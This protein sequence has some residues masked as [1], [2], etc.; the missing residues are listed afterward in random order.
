MPIDTICPS[1]ASTLRVA[2]A[3]AGRTARCPQ[4]GWTYQVP[5]ASAGCS[6]AEQD[7]VY[8]PREPDQRWQLRTPDGNLYGPVTKAILDLWVAEGRVTH[9]SSLCRLASGLWYAAAEIYPQLTP[10]PPVPAEPV[11]AAEPLVA[12]AAVQPG[13]RQAHTVSYVQQPHRG[14]T[15][16][17]LGVLGWLICPV[18]A[19]FTFSM[20]VRDLQAMRAGLMDPEG[21]S[22]TQV[23]VT[24]ALIEIG[25]FLLGV[26]LAISGRIL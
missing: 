14:L 1:C 26:A 3:H 18:I 21:L 13:L 5:T 10:A 8:H 4:C 9:D 20:G 15:I 23:G 25:V 12:S 22:L 17:M 19:P 6:P 16:L 11:L 24:L 7:T 2:D